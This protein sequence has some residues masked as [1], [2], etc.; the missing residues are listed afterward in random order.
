LGDANYCRLTAA[1]T[2]E[3]LN[4][5]GV[6]GGL[7]VRH[8]A[9]IHPARLARGLA[10]AVEKMGVK[11]FEQSP[12]LAIEGAVVR[13]P[14]AE[15]TAETI[16]LATEGYS[17][18]LPGLQRRLIPMHS[19]MVVT[20][21]L[22]QDQLRSINFR[23]RFTF[24]NCDRVVTYGQV[25]ADH[26]IAFG[27]RGMYLFG[28]GIKH[29]FAA[30]DPCFDFVSNTLLRFFPS[31]KGIGFT[32]A[33][34]GSMGVSRRL[35]PSVNYDPT[36]G[37]GWAGGYFG[38]GVGAAHLAGKTLADLVLQRDTERVH[39][40]WVNPPDEKKKWEREP[41]RWLGITS[42]SKLMHQVDQAEYSS[43]KTP[44]IRNWIL[45]RLVS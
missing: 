12:A 2:S 44:P 38:N 15:L 18:N 22:T 28:S 35:S 1:E 14:Q 26:R 13:T 43:G 19:M 5:D 36:T 41:L 8:C 3:S 31:L 45:E 10:T 27:C 29:R 4:I 25:T 37:H 24:G 30:S 11:I 6:L 34:G 32:H 7:F 16:I 20:E 17:C 39:T 33:W 23:Q 9:T 40:P 21:P 42:T